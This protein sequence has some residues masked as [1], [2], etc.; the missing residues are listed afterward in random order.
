MSS[1]YQLMRKDLKILVDERDKPIG[2]KWSFD[3]DNRHKL[4]KDIKLPAISYVEKCIETKNNYSLS[5]K[6]PSSLSSG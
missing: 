5:C 2:D 1:F 6:I 3:I 4:P